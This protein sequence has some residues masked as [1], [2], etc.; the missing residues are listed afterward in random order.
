[1]NGRV[2]QRGD[3]LTLSLA[4][5]DA[6]TGNQ[7]WGEQYNRKLTDLVALQSEIA[8]DVSQKLRLRLTSTEQQRLSKR[9]TEN[10]EAYQAYLKGWY[11]WSKYPA[12]SYE[13]SR[14]YFQQAIDLDPTYALAYSGLA[15]YY[16]F[17]STLGLLPPSENWPKGRRR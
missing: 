3:D 6:R 1:M 12:P 7:L 15:E 2:V 4:L 16:C 9:G 10:A 13:K 14:D 17:S 5:V 8:H 11:Y